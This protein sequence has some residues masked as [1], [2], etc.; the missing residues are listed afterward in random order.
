M[1]ARGIRNKNP[2]NIDFSPVMYLKDKWVGELGLED[3]VNPR[4][5]TFDTPEHGIRALCKILL[6]YHR[7][8][9]ASDGSAIDTV[10]EII[11]QKRN[12]STT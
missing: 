12:Q 6:T 1:Q 8:R 4:F 7:S 2:G 9:R 11:D 10:K 3:C 5:T